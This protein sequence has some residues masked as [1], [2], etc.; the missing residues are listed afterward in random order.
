MSSSND[1]ESEILLGNKQLLA[2]F[3]VVAIL[4]AISFTGGYMVGKNNGE[5][6]TTTASDIGGAA[7]SS[8]LVTRT[9]PPANAPDASA[10]SES[11]E[12]PHDDSQFVAVPLPAPDAKVTERAAAAHKSPAAALP[13]SG[14]ETNPVSTSFTPEAGQTFLQ[15]A[16]VGKDEADAVADVLHKKGFRAHSVQKPGSPK[17]YR[18]LIGPV[19]DAGDLAA[20]R[21]SLR[22]TGFREVIVQHY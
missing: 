15:V 11:K 20:T 19:K 12:A 3:A 7:D 13:P 2:V 22:K 16:A 6:K 5:K 17:L 21:D 14:A 9:V 1:N 10:P 18:V 4:L 8:V